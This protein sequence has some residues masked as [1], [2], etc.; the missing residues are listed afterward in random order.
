M[1]AAL[2]AVARDISVACFHDAPGSKDDLIVEVVGAVF[3]NRHAL[4]HL[5]TWVPCSRLSVALRT[6]SA[7]SN[8][9]STSDS[10]TSFGSQ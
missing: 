5:A 1:L 6:A 8:T 3:L 9:T 10:F 7:N 2:D 4:A